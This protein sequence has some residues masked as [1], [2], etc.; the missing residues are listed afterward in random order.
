MVGTPGCWGLAAAPL[1]IPLCAGQL[2]T[3]PRA[4]VRQIGI[5]F[6]FLLGLFIYFFNSIFLTPLPPVLERGQL[7]VAG[8]A[9]SREEEEEE[10]GPAW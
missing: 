9:C 8:T 5:Y 1:P 10:E 7:A 2:C 3:S 6:F 4:A